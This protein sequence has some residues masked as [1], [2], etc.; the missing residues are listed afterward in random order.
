M[1][2]ANSIASASLCE[3]SRVVNKRK[4]FSILKWVIFPANSIA[5]AAV[6]VYFNLRVFG[7]EDGVPYSI[8]VAMIGLFSIVIV[9][10]AESDNRTLGRAAFCFEIALTAMLI[11]NAAYSISVQ[12]KMSVARM[13]ET[14]QAATI[15]QIGKLRGSRTQREALQKIDKQESAQ[16]V[17]ADVERTLFWIMICELGLY[18]I[19]AFSLFAIAKL[20]DADEPVNV[21]TGEFPH[22]ID[23][24]ERLSLSLSQKRERLSLQ[25]GVRKDALKKLRK[26]L[27]DI[28]FHNPKRWFKADLVRGGVTIRLFERQHGHE[29]SLSQTTQSDKLLAAVDRP[30]FREKL[31]EELRR[32]GFEI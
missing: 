3:R 25:D 7:L 4:D 12:R 24:N 18:A 8:I 6:I 32:Q 14:S 21:K 17:F 2:Q 16:S 22:E 27:S 19:A 28:A 1:L 5:L 9:K 26:H 20:M 10:Y 30:D 11:L 23:A 29:I 15:E 31:I 13:G